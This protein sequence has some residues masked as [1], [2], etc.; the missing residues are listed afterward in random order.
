MSSQCCFLP[1]KSSNQTQVNIS[2]FNYQ[3]IP[4]NSAVLLIIEGNQQVLCFNNNKKAYFIIMGQRLNI[5]AV[6]NKIEKLEN[7]T[8]ISYVFWWYQL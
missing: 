1:I 3:S 5:S 4:K 7:C 2:I 8:I 6:M